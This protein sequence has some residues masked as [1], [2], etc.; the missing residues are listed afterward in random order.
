MVCMKK[1][2]ARPGLEDFTDHVMYDPILLALES[3]R[4]VSKPLKVWLSPLKFPVH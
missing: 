4:R 1:T 2:K 3:R